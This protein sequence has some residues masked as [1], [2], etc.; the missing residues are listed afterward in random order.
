MTT[1]TSTNAT[2]GAELA[3]ILGDVSK[4]NTDVLRSV[5]SQMRERATAF[6]NLSARNM[7]IHDA[8]QTEAGSQTNGNVPPVYADTLLALKA[9]GDVFKTNFDKLADRLE[10]DASGLIWIVENR[11]AIEAE[12]KKKLDATTTV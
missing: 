6:R 3:R 4:L 11:E 12:T 9:A 8:A 5:A 2:S 10:S 7:E 1:D